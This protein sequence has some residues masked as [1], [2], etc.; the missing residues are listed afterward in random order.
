MPNT[1]I[2]RRTL[3]GRDP[4]VIPFDPSQLGFT[5]DLRSPIEAL[6]ESSRHTNG[7]ITMPY[8]LIDPDISG[9]IDQAQGKTLTP[10]YTSNFTASTDG[11]AISLGLST[12]T[13]NETIGGSSGWMKATLDATS[14][15]HYFT[16]G[17]VAG[18]ANKMLKITMK[19][20]IPSTNTNVDGL[21]CVDVGI[22]VHNWTSSAA[23]A[24]P[25]DTVHEI[26]YYQ[27]QTGQYL[28]IYGYDGAPGSFTGTGD[29]VYVKDIVFSTV[30]GYNFIQGVSARSGHWDNTNFRT[31]LDAIDDKL[32]DHNQALAALIGSDTQGCM[33]VTARDNGG[34]GTNWFPFT[35][36]GSFTT[37]YLVFGFDSVNKFTILLYEGGAINTIA[38]TETYTGIRGSRFIILFQST[39]STYEVRIYDGTTVYTP[40]LSASVGAVDGKYCNAITNGD[41]TEIAAVSQV[42]G[43]YAVGF[44]DVKLR[45][46]PLNL[47]TE[48]PNLFEWLTN[49]YY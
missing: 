39:G 10:I 3:L 17:A 31:N 9:Y 47:S 5:L 37:S 48:W 35:Y 40:T 42:G 6:D 33:I 1:N 13:Y 46:T 32:I 26:T 7:L 23:N 15:A 28:R 30:A 11:F 41:T 20:Y 44:K 45:R 8:T 18:W 36:S 49:R 27:F 21:G 34:A 12:L 19:V 22:N 14:G 16:K 24:I 38:S 2:I 4:A 25:L 43:F 29:V